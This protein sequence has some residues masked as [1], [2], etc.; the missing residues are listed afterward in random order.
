MEVKITKFGWGST[1]RAIKEALEKIG[2]DDIAFLHFKQVYP[3]Y[4]D[5]KEHI[6]KA[7]KTMIF[8]NN[9]TNQFGMLIRQATGIEVE[10]KALKYNGMPFSVEEVT[11][12]LENLLEEL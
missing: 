7:Q 4:E 5:V 10:K 11:E 3:L 6:K 8:E 12:H 2:R 9:A 1:Y